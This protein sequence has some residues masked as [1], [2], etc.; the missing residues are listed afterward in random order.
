M[1]SISESCSL[2][3]IDT[4]LDDLLDQMEEQ[5]DTEGEPSEDLVSRFREFCTAHG[6][7]VDRIGRFVRMIESREQYCRAEAAR[8]GDRAR[9]A[10]NKV[11]RT[12]SMVLYYLMSREI[13]KVEGREFTLRIQKNSQDTVR[14][15]DE[16]AIP[17]AY[18]R[19]EVRSG[20]ALWE[21]ILSYL[22]HE[23]ER[24]LAACV[25]ESRPDTEAI[26]TA[27]SRHEQVPA[28]KCGAALV[29][30]WPDRATGKRI[31]QIRLPNRI[32]RH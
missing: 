12:K 15:L 14:V 7:K 4:E 19:V 27:V 9:A 5:I 18:Q 1:A 30:E 17:M 6:E 21:T 26:K 16:S 20:G 11:D 22:P 29:Y 10:A 24:S 28:L 2:F 13:K 3:Q 32:S 31:L 8:L 25:R 23:L